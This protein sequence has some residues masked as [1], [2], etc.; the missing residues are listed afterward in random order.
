MTST[1]STVVNYSIKDI[2]QR[3]DRIKA[4]NYILHDLKDVF[5]FPREVKKRISSTDVNVER[6]WETTIDFAFN[7]K[8]FSNECIRESI[9]NAL[10]DV[11]KS[12]Q[13]LAMTVEENSWNI[14]SMSVV[15]ESEMETNVPEN[16]PNDC[17]MSIDENIVACTEE[18]DKVFQL[19]SDLRESEHDQEQSTTS[20]DEDTLENTT[21]EFQND[22]NFKDFSSRIEKEDGGK[23]SRKTYKTGLFVT[24]KVNGKPVVIKKSSLCWLLDDTKGRV[25]TDRLRRFI[26]NS[27]EAKT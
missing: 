1:L 26:N 13:G 7:C 14:L 25:S 4:I 27:K 9:E 17:E 24:V 21:L 8:A 20:G 6:S 10:R 23:T 18:A 12:T 3:L 11:I 2:M 5:T 22:L 19:A 15:M 16:V